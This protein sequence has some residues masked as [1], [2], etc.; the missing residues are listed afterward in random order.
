M[1]KFFTRRGDDGTSAAI[2]GKRGYKDNLRFDLLGILDEANATLNL[3][4]LHMDEKQDKERLWTIQKDLQVIM[5]EVAGDR[6]SN[7]NQE[8]IEWLEN[9]ITRL[10]EGMLMPVEF[11]AVWTKPSSAF[12]NLARTV[13]RRAERAAVSFAR[14]QNHTNPSEVGYLN[15]LSSLLFVLQLKMENPQFKG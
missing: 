3:A 1:N 7:I 13:V 15:R 9:E 5:A 10:G 14:S 2:A 6:N 8:R 4:E 11:I 12:L